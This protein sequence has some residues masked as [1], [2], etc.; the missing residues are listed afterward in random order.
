M[1]DGSEAAEM[2]AVQVDTPLR[3]HDCR[4]KS[5]R[6][7][8][9]GTLSLQEAGRDGMAKP[10]RCMMHGIC[11]SSLHALGALCLQPVRALLA[12]APSRIG[13]VL[14][15]CCASH[16]ACIRCYSPSRCST[17]VLV[18]PD[19]LISIPICGYIARSHDAG[20]CGILVSS[21]P[22]AA[23]HAALDGRVLPHA[24]RSALL[25]KM[26]FRID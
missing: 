18:R 26:P 24:R 9:A 22:L 15:V 16:Q 12:S 8:S 25:L 7:M 4:L 19:S 6:H 5:T 10:G 13:Q 14:C 1:L 21:R 20:A 17:T 2:M 23:Q 11:P 3:G